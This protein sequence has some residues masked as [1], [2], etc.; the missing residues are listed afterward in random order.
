MAINVWLWVKMDK[1]GKE[2]DENIFI[3]NDLVYWLIVHCL[4]SLHS[5]C[6][7]LSN[8]TERN[9]RWTH[10]YKC[11]YHSG[12]YNGAP[13]IRDW[14]ECQFVILCDKLLFV[15]YIAFNTILFFFFSF[16]FFLKI[17]YNLLNKIGSRQI[18]M[19]TF[20]LLYSLSLLYYLTFAVINKQSNCI[21]VREYVFYT[22][23]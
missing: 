19:N 14:N 10:T 3:K 1:V 13:F 22:K 4:F 17:F 21:W 8:D 16:L 7:A 2:K 12:F 11:W 23:F 15:F 9:C 5:K 6:T 18:C 20:L